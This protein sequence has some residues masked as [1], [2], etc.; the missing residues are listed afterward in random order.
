V[1]RKRLEVRG[2]IRLLRIFLSD[3]ERDERREDEERRQER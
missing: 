3:S 1:R 2:R